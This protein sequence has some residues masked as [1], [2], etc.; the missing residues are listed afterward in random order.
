VLVSSTFLSLF[1]SI[2]VSI[3]L[4]RYSY[5]GALSF[6]RFLLLFITTLLLFKNT[7]PRSR[8][9]EYEN[10]KR[11]KKKEDKRIRE[12]TIFIKHSYYSTRISFLFQITICYSYRFDMFL[13]FNFIQI[14]NKRMLN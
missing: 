12:K 8:G 5:N 9:R 2:S 11:S 4:L 1:L 6:S 7:L 10:T 14:I 3:F 13:I